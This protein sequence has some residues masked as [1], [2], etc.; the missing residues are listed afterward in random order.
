MHKWSELEAVLHQSMTLYQGLDAKVMAHAACSHMG[1]GFVAKRAAA[2]ARRTPHCIGTA[3]A[4]LA[5]MGLAM[6]PS[7]TS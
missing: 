6:Q 1:L 2:P 7:D 3:D 4:I 5:H